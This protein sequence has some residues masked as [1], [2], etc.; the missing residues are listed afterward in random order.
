[1]AALLESL[2]NNHRATIQG[3]GER[4]RNMARSR[5][6]RGSVN[7]KGVCRKCG[8]NKWQLRYY[9]GLHDDGTRD[10]GSLTIHAS[11]KKEAD[12][13]LSEI[14]Q[15]PHKETPANLTTARYLDGWLDDVVRPSVAP[16][17][18][19]DYVAL[20]RLYVKPKIGSRKLADLRAP[21]VRRVYR[22]MEA[23]GLSP[24]T[25]RYTHTVL[26]AAMTQAVEDGLL[27]GN[28]AAKARKSIPRAVRHE[29]EVLTPDQIEQF[30]QT[31]RDAKD[32]GR[33]GGRLIAL[34]EF[35]AGTG[36]RPS[37]ALGLRWSEVNLDAGTVQIVRTLTQ[38]RGGE[39]HDGEGKTRTSRRQFPLPPDLTATLRAHRGQQDAERE[40]AGAAWQ[41]R[42]LVFCTQEGKPLIQRNVVRA[43]K[44]LLAAAGLPESVRVYD[45]RHTHA[46]LL[47]AGGQNPKVVAERLGH[48][49]VNLTLNTYSHVLPHM[50]QEAADILQTLLYRRRPD[51]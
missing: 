43:F 38:T 30:W 35:L 6:P 34:F 12:R 13:R 16:K 9:R 21:D 23:A 14:E 28:P 31:A 4:G 7:P 32:Q 47:L 25:I 33:Q 39:W 48:A 40:F 45:L 18:H 2:P 20:M 50:Q 41:D 51:E 44:A 29:M 26:N 49:N 24:R 22:E 10:Y 11:T 1:V 3:R 19:Q 17:T 42:G 46:T 36:C 5:R 37:E 15:A 27:K 8:E